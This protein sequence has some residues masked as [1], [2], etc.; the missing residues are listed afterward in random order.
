MRE[1]G[2]YR[3]RGEGGREEEGREGE[4]MGRGRGN[5]RIKRTIECQLQNCS[6]SPSGCLLELFADTSCIIPGHMF[7]L[8]FLWPYCISVIT[9][10]IHDGC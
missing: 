2:R 8:W 10:I 5:E 7:V 1:R 6:L 4:M 3:G 9:L